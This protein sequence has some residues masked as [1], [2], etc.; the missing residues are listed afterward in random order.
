M[1]V[2][3]DYEKVCKMKTLLLFTIIYSKINSLECYED[4]NKLPWQ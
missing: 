1:E 4:N 2:P 3:Y